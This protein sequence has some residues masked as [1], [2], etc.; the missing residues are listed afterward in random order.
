MSGDGVKINSCTNTADGAVDCFGH[1]PSP[2]KIEIENRL[3]EEKQL[4]QKL[5]E[6]ATQ[7]EKSGVQLQ[8]L[9]AE[10]KEQLTSLLK[11]LHSVLSLRLKDLRHKEVK[12]KLGERKCMAKVG[13]RDWKTSTY[14]LVISHI[15][16][17]L[18]DINETESTMIDIVDELIDICAHNQD[19][20]NCLGKG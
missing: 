16:T 7:Y 14:Q 17:L 8:T 15:K 2:T 18:Y 12:T 3:S 4:L 1:E 9:T 11:E 20:E 5:E 10:D 19:V 6:L 13:N